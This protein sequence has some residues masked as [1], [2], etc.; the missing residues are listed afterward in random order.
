MT[1]CRTQMGSHATP[2]RFHALGAATC[3]RST[4]Q[5]CC[6]LMGIRPVRVLGPGWCS[7]RPPVLWGVWVVR[8]QNQGFFRA[9]PP[10]WRFLPRVPL[11]LSPLHL[12]IPL[13]MQQAQGL[14]GLREKRRQNQGS[15]RVKPPVWRFHPQ[16]PLVLSPLLLVL[17]STL[18][19]VCLQILRS[20][21]VHCPLV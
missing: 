18:R 19:F 5:A 14:W 20:P 21:A 4:G 13:A 8:R 2:A 16:G 7:L 15:F 3:M 1:T 10:M 12:V 9:K 11:V 6:G 17:P